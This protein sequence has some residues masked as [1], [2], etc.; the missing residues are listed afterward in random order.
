MDIRE[1]LTHSIYYLYYV[2]NA[3]L[4]SREAKNKYEYMDWSC[5]RICYL[6]DGGSI[7]TYRYIKYFCEANHEVSLISMRPV[8]DRIKNLGVVVWEPKRQFNANL[9][10]LLYNL[11][12]LPRILYM[13]RKMQCDILH[14]HD[15]FAYGIF[16]WISRK[17]YVLSPWGSD[18]L[19]RTRNHLYGFFIKHVVRNAEAI[20]YDGGL[21]MLQALEDLGADRMKIH[22]L[23]FGVDVEQFSPAKKKKNFS[24]IPV[25]L[26]T[27]NLEP[28]YN[29][30]TFIH[31]IAIVLKKYQVK[32][33]IV[34]D[35]SQRKE[36]EQLAKELGVSGH[37]VFKGR[38]SLSEMASLLASADIYV[39]TALS[40]AGLAASTAEAMASGVPVIVSDFGDNSAWVKNDKNGYLFKLRDSQDLS[41]RIIDLLE[42]PEKR[43]RF[44]KMNVRLIKE[45]NNYYVEMSKV[46]K[47]Y[48]TISNHHD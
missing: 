46:H 7:H 35:G 40:D 39:S 2:Y 1:I 17:K 23:Y 16:A 21:H 47:I 43:R 22:K 18:I 42:S 8:P 27:R 13:I 30:A 44:G 36:L 10:F 12:L 25:V 4:E 34:G 20:L 38:V 45:R 41:Y 32:A 5:M 6:A 48:K 14:A 9:L 26:S 29:I 31:A 3:L 33:I 37:V 19:V 28:I 11:L 24:K 15:A